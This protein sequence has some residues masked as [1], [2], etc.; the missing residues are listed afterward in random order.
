MD[1]LRNWIPERPIMEQAMKA[2]APH[3][4]A[5]MDNDDD[6]DFDFND[7]PPEDDSAELTDIVWEG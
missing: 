5:C 4:L 6:D 7:L 1:E 3:L 2:I